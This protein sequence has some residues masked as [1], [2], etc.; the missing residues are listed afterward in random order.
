MRIECSKNCWTAKP[1]KRWS[2][3]EVATV[4]EDL[5]KRLLNNKNFTLASATKGQVTSKDKENVKYRKTRSAGSG[6]RSDSG[7]NNI[8]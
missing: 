2:A 7:N 6:D 1:E 5:G 4:P 3:G 8:S